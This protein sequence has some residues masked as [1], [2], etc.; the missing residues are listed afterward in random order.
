MQVE[1]VRRLSWECGRGDMAGEAMEV[2]AVRRL[3][4]GGGRGV[5]AGGVWRGVGQFH[6][7]PIFSSANIFDVETHF[8]RCARPFYVETLWLSANLV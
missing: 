4:W 8:R 1:A 5:F 3:S 6:F 2:E 7:G